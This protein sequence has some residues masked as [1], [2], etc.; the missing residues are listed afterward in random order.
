MGMDR[1]AFIQGA[2][3]VAVA[4]FLANIKSLTTCVKPGSVGL[5]ETSYQPSAEMLVRPIEFRIRGWHE[6]GYATSSTGRTSSDPQV[7]QVL[8]SVNRAWR[9]VWR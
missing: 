6:S 9:T 4:P 7:D 1:R 8:I 3:I 5:P 2:A